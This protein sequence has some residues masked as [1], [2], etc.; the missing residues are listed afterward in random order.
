MRA[1]NVIQG[2]KFTRAAKRRSTDAAGWAGTSASSLVTG[3]KDRPDLGP[4]VV[5]LSSHSE[6][7]PQQREAILGLPAHE[8]AVAAGRSISK[9]VESAGRHAVI[10]LD[11][12]AG[13]AGMTRA[14]GRQICGLF[15][16]GDMADWKSVLCNDGLTGLQALTPCR[17]ARVPAAPLRALAARSPAIAE[18]FWRDSLIHA[19][20]L[21]QWMVNLGRRSAEERI[22]HLI[23]EIAARYGKIDEGREASFPLPL[24]QTQLADALGLT[25]VHVNRCL[26]SLA[27]AGLLRIAR[28]TATLIDRARAIDFADFDPWY[29]R[30]DP[31]ASDLH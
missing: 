8:V 10:M 13:R 7:D 24:T 19:A 31:A 1:T 17:I 18:A 2:T 15:L 6:L 23:C 9:P 30:L 4:F 16:P 11:G 21:E 25:S 26:K 12:L 5:H 20:T 14:G 28:R 29:L 22:A 3:R 27:A